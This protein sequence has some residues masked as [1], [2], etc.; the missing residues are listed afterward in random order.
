MPLSTEVADRDAGSSM[1]A[2]TFTQVIFNAPS[3]VS[4]ATT[5][6]AAV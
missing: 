3:L 1:T 4:H 5:A 2:A 6:F